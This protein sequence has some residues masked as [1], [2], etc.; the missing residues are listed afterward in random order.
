MEPCILLVLTIGLIFLTIGIAWAEP[1]PHQPPPAAEAAQSPN[2][3]S[4]DE[5]DES[6]ST[7][8]GMGF[9]SRKDDAAEPGQQRTEHIVNNW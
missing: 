5:E 9:E 3:D 1:G 7:W 6:V 8:F 4:W 2:I